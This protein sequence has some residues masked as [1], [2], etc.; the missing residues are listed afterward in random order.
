MLTFW[1]TPNTHKWPPPYLDWGPSHESTPR[2]TDVGA[3]WSR[4]PFRHHLWNPARLWDWSDWSIREW[5]K[6]DSCTERPRWS[7]PCPLTET[8]QQCRNSECLS[9]EAGLWYR[10]EWG[11]WL[12]WAGPLCRGVVSGYWE[13]EAAVDTNCT[14][15][16]PSAPL[17]WPCSYQQHTFS[18]D[19]IR[20]P[21]LHRGMQQ[22]NVGVLIGGLPV[23]K[24]HVRD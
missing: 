9:V 20:F 24:I 13:E 19:L 15:C 21:Q 16:Q 17:I 4:F 10:P 11:G 7:E 8:H 6:A 3:L 18:W 5:S 1:F 23:N 14:W 2:R 12:A 22:V